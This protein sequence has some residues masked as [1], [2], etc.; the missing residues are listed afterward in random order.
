MRAEDFKPVATLLQLKRMR[1]RDHWLMC[2][3]P[4]APIKHSEGTD[5]HP[6]FGIELNEPISRYNCF[7]CGSKG[8]LLMLPNA[9]LFTDCKLISASRA[10]EAQSYIFNNETFGGLEYGSDKVLE[11]IEPLP[12]FAFEQFE[13]VNV[14]NR[15]YIKHITAPIVKNFNLRFDIKYNRIVIPIYNLEGEMVGI[16]GRQEGKDSSG[17][18]YL[19]YTKLHPKRHDPKAFGVWY[20]MHRPYDK[21]K[22]L[23]LVEGE[24]DFI[25]MVAFLKLPNVW[26][27]MGAEIS[28]A[29]LETLRNWDVSNLV[30]FFDND[31]G[32]D[33]AATSVIKALLG[34]YPIYKVS[35]YFGYKDPSDL[36]VNKKAKKSLKSLKK[37]IEKR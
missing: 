18:P 34:L 22:P 10:I 23:I 19:S 32:G 26:C 11:D 1:M 5:K 14:T 27:S 20:G 4:F 2:S 12:P 6:S 8:T 16:R 28:K 13:E 36:C 30:L 31:K 3:C 15:I 9:L 17:I 25:H 29:Q 37:I 33:I 7:S 24:F 35:Q 21:T